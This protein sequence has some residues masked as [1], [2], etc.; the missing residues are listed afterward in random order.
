MVAA[1][2]MGMWAVV[3]LPLAVALLVDRPR[4][5]LAT[6]EATIRGF[7]RSSAAAL[8]APARV[9][10]SARRR[11]LVLVAL[12]VPVALTLLGAALNPTRTALAAQAL[13]DQVLVAYLA[14]LVA[15]RRAHLA[16]R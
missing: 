2:I 4:S 9:Q 1:V 5:S 15:T 10:R 11:H 16:R 7:E 13:A 8:G 3:L 12:C 14:A 6:F